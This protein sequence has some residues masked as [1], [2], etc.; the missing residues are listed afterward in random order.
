M[1]YPEQQDVVWKKGPH[2]R[3]WGLEKTMNNHVVMCQSVSF[4]MQVEFP[5]H[6]DGPPF[7]QHHT[8]SAASFPL[9]INCTF[10]IGGAFLARRSSEWGGLCHITD[11]WITQGNAAGLHRVVFVL[12]F[13]FPRTHISMQK[14]TNKQKKKSVFYIY[15]YLL[16]NPWP[17][18]YTR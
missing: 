16:R 5:V 15:I 3:R 2:R 13:F 11:R 17:N 8:F 7:P 18:L 6:L 9:H 12:F 4:L 14:Y 1:I 10:F